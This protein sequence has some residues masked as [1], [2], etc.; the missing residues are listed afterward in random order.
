MSWSRECQSCCWTDQAEGR[1]GSRV[2]RSLSS[3]TSTSLLFC[4]TVFRPP[5][6]AST[7]RPQ[8]TPL[9]FGEASHT[10]GFWHCARAV[11]PSPHRDRTGSAG[12]RVGWHAGGHGAGLAQAAASSPSG[13]G[14]GHPLALL[15]SCAGCLCLI[16]LRGSCTHRKAV[17]IP[18]AA[19]ACAGA[20]PEEEL[21]R[22]RGRLT[23]RQGQ[24][25]D[26]RMCLGWASQ[27][28][29]STSC[30]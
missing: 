19:H 24:M 9:G 25:L 15:G 6:S 26:H 29:S 13:G 8:K 3:T 7:S 23:G 1:E 21:A 2:Q 17:E 28:A 30:C 10:T 20:S 4:R 14:T 16:P 12:L 5:H 11:E 22:A 18:S 27:A